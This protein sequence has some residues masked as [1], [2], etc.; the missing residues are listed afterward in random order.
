MGWRYLISMIP[1]PNFIKIR[2]LGHVHD[3][4]VW[5]WNLTC[6]LDSF[7]NTWHFCTQKHVC[8]SGGSRLACGVVREAGQH[9]R[10]RRSGGCGSWVVGRLQY[11]E[12]T[13][14]G[15]T[16]ATLWRCRRGRI[17]GEGQGEP[18]GRPSSGSSVR[19]RINPV[20][21]AALWWTA[22]QTHLPLATY[23]KT[24]CL[25]AKSKLMLITF[26]SLPTDVLQHILWHH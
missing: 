1:T 11:G 25:K 8:G 2:Y 23:T 19:T 14:V 7:Q 15:W 9:C 26:P 20:I 4:T 13:R 3:D 16:I 21:S 5:K 6:V 10:V 18:W 12:R 24:C 22:Q 17:G